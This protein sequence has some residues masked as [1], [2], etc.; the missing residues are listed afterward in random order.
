MVAD[1]ADWSDGLRASLAGGRARVARLT[2]WRRELAEEVALLPDTMRRFRNG[3]AKFELVGERLAK[4]SASLE[5]ITD[6]Y[7]STIGESG[8]KSAQALDALRSQVETLTQGSTSPE[9]MS[10]SI[11]EIRQALDGFADFNP[12]WPGSGRK[13]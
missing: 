13:R 4:S 1:R 8:K 6:I 5:G 12:W 2:E 11:D 3:A 9:K 10:S 7:Q